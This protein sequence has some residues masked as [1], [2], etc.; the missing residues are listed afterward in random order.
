MKSRSSRCAS[1]GALDG[2]PVAAARQHLHAARGGMQPLGQG[3]HRLRRRHAVL[4]A[5][6]QQHRAA[7]C[8]PPRRLRVGQRLAAA[9][10]GL[11]VL[12]HQALAHEGHGQR[13]AL[14]RARPTAPPAA[15][16]RVV[17]AG[18]RLRCAPWPPAR[19]CRARMR[20][21]APAGAEQ[22]QAAHQLR[23]R[24]RQVLADDGAHRMA[25]QVR[26]DMPSRVQAAQRVDEDARST[27]GPSA[28]LRAAAAGQVDAQHA[29]A[30]QR[31][32]Q[33]REDVLE[34]PP[35]P[36]TQTTASPSP[37]S[38]TA[39]RS[40]QVQ[41]G[42]RHHWKRFSMAPMPSI[43]MRTTSPCAQPARRVQ[44]HAHAGRRA[45]GDDVARA[46]A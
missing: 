38:S 41:Q 3:A 43:S 31:R 22:R 19:A 45:G 11:A 21:A 15:A 28:R 34:L 6:D 14:P 35:R 7:R 4:V 30:R 36:C 13:L 46:A 25:D 29:V 12:A 42:M 16:P 39:M 9:R 5:G 1:S 40:I 32:H 24:H 37:S 33:R 10:V 18:R 27:A 23:R 17:H 20:R 8:L 2:C 26:A 44:A